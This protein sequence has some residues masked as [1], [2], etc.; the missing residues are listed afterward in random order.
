MVMCNRTL[1]A[2][3]DGP[4]GKILI[5]WLNTQFPNTL[6]LVVT[7][8]KNDIFRY[9]ETSKIVVEEL[10]GRTIEAVVHSS[11]G[12]KVDIGLLLWWPKIL[13]SA[14]IEVAKEGFINTHPSLLPFHRG[15]NP[16]FWAL[17]SGEP[18][19]VSLHFLGSGIDDGDL[20]AQCEIFYDWTDNAET[21]YRKGQQGIIDLFKA[22]FPSIL[23]GSTKRLKQSLNTGNFHYAKEMEQASCLDLSSVQTIKDTLNLLRARTFPGH[24]SC[25]F[26]DELGQEY[27]VRVMIQKRLPQNRS[28]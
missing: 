7:T 22:T 11:L 21:L 9:C 13:K 4:V 24:P 8:S 19:G 5:E 28:S 2:C 18:F 20:V 12:A 26:I 25:W 1:V 17:K 23:N 27:E 16:N 6:S 14:D 10:R 15:K 3:A